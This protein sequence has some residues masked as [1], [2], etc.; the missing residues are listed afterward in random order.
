MEI[1]GEKLGKITFLQK[2]GLFC[3]GSPWQAISRRGGGLCT[4]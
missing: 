1:V 2:K 4:V 3:Y